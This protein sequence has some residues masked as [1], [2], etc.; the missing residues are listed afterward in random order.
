MNVL[1]QIERLSSLS[2]SKGVKETLKHGPRFSSR[3]G[4][5]DKGHEW[6]RGVRGSRPS[7]GVRRGPE[8]DGV[9][10]TKGNS[11]ELGPMDLK[12]ILLLTSIYSLGRVPIREYSRVRTLVILSEDEGP[13]VARVVFVSVRLGWS[14]YL[15]PTGHTE[16]TTTF[17]RVGPD[18]STRGTTGDYSFGGPRP[19][20]PEVV[21]YENPSRSRDLS[22]PPTVTL[23]LFTGEA[24]SEFLPGVG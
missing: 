9:S 17:R 7:L 24:S 11:E 22:P 4:L 13:K 15:R 5:V 18:T 10:L 6:G 19:P 12:V 1:G 8:T 2:R 23:R 20:D 14:V 21:G 3:S 16:G